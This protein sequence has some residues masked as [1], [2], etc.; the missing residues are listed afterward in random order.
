[1]CSAG[2]EDAMRGP[3]SQ[4]TSMCGKRPLLNQAK[5]FYQSHGCGHIISLLGL[6]FPVCKPSTSGRSESERKT[7]EYQL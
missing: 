3:S 4:H 2:G 5:G 7:F 1:M 6:S